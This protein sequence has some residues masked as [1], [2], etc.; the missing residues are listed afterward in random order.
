VSGMKPTAA[1]EDFLVEP[2]RVL[3]GPQS[4]VARAMEAGSVAAGRLEIGTYLSASTGRFRKTLMGCSRPNC[5]VGI[6]LRAGS[7]YRRTPVF[8]STR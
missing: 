3:G 5:G 7:R 4:A 6:W 2:A 8:A 1:G